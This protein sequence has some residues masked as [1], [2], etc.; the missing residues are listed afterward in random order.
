M[1]RVRK[2]WVVLTAN[3]ALV[4]VLIIVGVTAHSVGVWAE[5]V[6]YLADAAAIGVTLLA[7]RWTAPT[8]RR[9]QGMPRATRYVALVNAGWL[10]VLTLLVGAG[11]LDRLLTGIHEVHGLPVLVVSTVAAAV[12]LGAALLLGGEVDHDPGGHEDLPVRAVLLETG[13]DAAAAAGVAGTGAVIFARRG[14]YW[15]DPTVA[16]AIAVAVGYHA[17]RLLS[18]IS[19]SLRS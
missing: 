12:M 7:I 8:E 19:A 3:V 4:G 10:F 5:G 17:M 11:A 14:F 9:P 2:L 13:A 6:D 1:T 16:L 15:L 18:R